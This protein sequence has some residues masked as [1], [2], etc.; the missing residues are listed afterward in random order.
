MSQKTRNQS[1]PINFPIGTNGN[2]EV[3][4]VL[5]RKYA[6]ATGIMVLVGSLGGATFVRVGLRD[7]S[8][9]ILD[10]TNSKFLE[11]GV[12]CPKPARWTPMDIP[13]NGSNMYVQIQLPYALSSA[14]QLDVVFLLQND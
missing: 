2:Q 7:E 12:E 14:L 4:I 6:R 1:F 3:M 11:A 9:T 8:S 5:D 13:A 10:P